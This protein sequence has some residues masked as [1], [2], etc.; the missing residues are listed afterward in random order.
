MTTD[1]L[2]S[3]A[4]RVAALLPI[5][6]ICAEVLL[7]LL[8]WVGDVYDWGIDNLLDA[9]GLAWFFASLLD[10]FRKA[11]LAELTLVLLTASLAWESGLPNMFTRRRHSLSERRA[12]QFLVT[13]ALLSVLA[14]IALAATSSPLIVSSL[15]TFRGAPLHR[16]AFPLVLLWLMGGALIFGWSS[17]RLAGLDDAL[18]LG[19]LL[20]SQAAPC[21]ATLFFASQLLAAVCFVFP[22]FASHAAPFTL[23]SILLYAP[24]PLLHILASVNKA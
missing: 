10:N 14:L 22:H 16:A 6:Y 15:G 11:P 13:Y 21:F 7:M 3:V 19:G 2:A 8:S 1:R 4:A 20:L 17:G 24:P 12:L 9:E 5:V 18:R 23:L